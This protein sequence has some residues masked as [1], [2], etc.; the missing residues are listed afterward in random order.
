M[1]RITEYV[2]ASTIWSGAKD[3]Q[4]MGHRPG[5]VRGYN[6]EVRRNSDGSL[7]W[8]S[9]CYIHE[10]PENYF[11][12]ESYSEWLFDLDLT[13][14]GRISFRGYGYESYDPDERE[15]YVVK[16]PDNLVPR[17]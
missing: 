1:F 8:M 14:T 7:G 13:P 3:H 12:S 16:V 4:E 6:L 17:Y 2:P 5:Y 15:T 11:S 10:E 9:C